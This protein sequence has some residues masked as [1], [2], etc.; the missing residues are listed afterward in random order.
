MGLYPADATSTWKATALIAEHCGPCY[1]RLGPPKALILYGPGEQIGKY[2]VLWKSDKDQVLVVAG[3]VTVFEA[4]TAYEQLQKEAILIR[5]I[6]LFS[7]QPVDRDELIASACRRRCRHHRRRSLCAWWARDAVLWALA[8]ERV[9]AYKLA[10]REIPHSGKPA[11]CE[12]RYFRRSY[13]ERGQVRLR[14]VLTET[15]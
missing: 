10:V 12:V 13:R 11:D 7:V 1:L 8:E 6:D 9:R 3:G 5:V 4:L 14:L 15:I 2:K